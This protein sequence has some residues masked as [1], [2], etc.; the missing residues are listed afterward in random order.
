[1][2]MARKHTIRTRDGGR[3]T[4]GVTRAMAIKLFCVECLGWE[5]HPRECSAKMCALWVYRGKTEAS[6]MGD[7]EEGAK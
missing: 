7:K 1:M 6:L 2:V 5:E 3:K 4:I